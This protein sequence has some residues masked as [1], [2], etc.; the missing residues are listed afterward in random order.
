MESKP[1]K[2]I[3]KTQL[4]KDVYR[5]VVDGQGSEFTAPGQFARIFSAAGNG[6]KLVSVSEFDSDR[7]I[8][9]FRA[10]DAVGE[11]LSELKVGDCFEADLGIGNGFDIDAIPDDCIIAGEGMG[12]PPILGILRRLFMLGKDC[13]VVLC[14]ESKEDMFLLKPFLN[15]AT[16]LEIFT[17]DGSNANKGHIYNA[18]HDAK[19]VCACASDAV[20]EWTAAR[21]EEGQFASIEFFDGEGPVFDRA[22]FE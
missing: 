19:Y 6:T 8:L 10:D 2:I 15:L 21:C 4:N 14:Y 12:I 22:V 17:L 13:K 3:E 16:E 20:L 7:Y 9:I 18:I 11:E 5:F 1:N